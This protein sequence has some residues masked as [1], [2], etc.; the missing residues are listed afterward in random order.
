MGERKE[1]HFLNALFEM[2]MRC[3]RRHVENTVEPMS[4]EVRKEVQTGGINLGGV[5]I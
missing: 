5:G 1:D 4:L 3:L 2:S